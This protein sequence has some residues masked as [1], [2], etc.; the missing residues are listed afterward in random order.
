MQSHGYSAMA[1][2][3]LTSRLD[4]G[5]VELGIAFRITLTTRPLASTPAAPTPAQATA[6]IMGEAAEPWLFAP[7]Q[8][9]ATRLHPPAYSCLLTN[10]GSAAKRPWHALLANSRNI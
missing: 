2:S 10:R 3:E 4:C 6:I 1:L 9:Y 8:R 7:A 5:G